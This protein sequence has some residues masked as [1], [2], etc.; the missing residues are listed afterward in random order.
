M[1]EEIPIMPY[2]CEEEC[3]AEMVFAHTEAP[4]IGLHCTIRCCKLVERKLSTGA[5]IWRY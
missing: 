3:I 2:S 4:E 5:I 1:I